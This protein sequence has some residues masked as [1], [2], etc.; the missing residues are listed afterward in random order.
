VREIKKW[1]SPIREFN[2]RSFHGLEFFYRKF[3][4]NFSSICSPI[5]DTI[6]KN[7]RS[8]NWIVEDEKGIRVLK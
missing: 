6:K 5:L 7:H 1:P 8:F 2:I 3:I 4:R